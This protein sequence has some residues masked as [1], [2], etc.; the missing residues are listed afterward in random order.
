MAESWSRQK[1]REPRH[2]SE[3]ALPVAVGWRCARLGAAL[4]RSHETT[5][6]P[7]DRPDGRGTLNSVAALTQAEGGCVEHPEFVVYKSNRRRPRPCSSA[8]PRRPQAPRGTVAMTHRHI[9]LD[10]TS[11]RVLY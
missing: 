11:T 10:Q 8:P 7:P 3:L 4:G 9:A 2:V 5:Q 6:L 1:L